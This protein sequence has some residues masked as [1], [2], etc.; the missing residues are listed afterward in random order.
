MWRHAYDGSATPRLD[1][2][3]AGSP[4]RNVTLSLNHSACLVVHGGAVA[5]TYWPEKS[6][7][8]GA[9]RFQTSDLAELQ[10]DR[11]FLR[12]RLSDEI[13]VAGRK[14]SPESI[15]GVLLKHP[16][17]RECL[18]FG[19]P[20]RDAE[21]TETIVA[22]VVSGATEAELKRFLLQCLP[23][24]QVPREWCFVE[25]LSANDRGKISRVEWRRRW[26][27]EKK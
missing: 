19:A 24:W 13:N 12:G 16:E 21:R 11:V 2:T 10:N 5:E 26:Q 15:E 25:T 8:L 18:V 22:V 14:V 7:L 9:G 3:L 20:S 4:M 27:A 17:V 1:E 23:A 6:G